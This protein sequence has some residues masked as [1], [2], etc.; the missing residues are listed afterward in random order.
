MFGLFGS[1]SPQNAYVYSPGGGISGAAISMVGILYFGSM[2]LYVYQQVVNPDGS[3]KEDLDVAEIA[4]D[5]FVN[6]DPEV[7]ATAIMANL[8]GQH[9]LAAAAI[10]GKIGF[11]EHIRN[12]KAG[13]FGVKIN[14]A[15]LALAPSLT[16]EAWDKTVDFLSNI[17]NEV[18]KAF[19]EQTGGFTYKNFEGW[20]NDAIQSVD[21]NYSFDW[22]SLTS[23][24]DVFEAAWRVGT[25]QN[26]QGKGIS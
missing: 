11:A 22:E 26:N 24:P 13:W 15:E 17:L 14:D 18:T 23:L 6:A 9:S 19:N 10:L 25:Q 12:L 5:T 21:P 2:G 1:S 3:L 20:V 4:R 16:G 7:V 8:S